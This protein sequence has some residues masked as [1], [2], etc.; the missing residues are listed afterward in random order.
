MRYVIKVPG[1]HPVRLNQLV[2]AHWGT[3]A[4][5]KRA[6]QALLSVYVRLAGVPPA[7]G[8]RRVDLL[9]TLGPGQRAG[10]PDAYLKSLLDA[11]VVTGRLTDDNRQGVELGAV[12]FERGRQASTTISLTDLEGPC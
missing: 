4:K 1:W 5:R 9:I 7:T 10:D 8:R 11:L 6:D 2:G 3:R 12:E